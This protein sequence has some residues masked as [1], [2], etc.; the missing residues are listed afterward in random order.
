MKILA[1]DG[2]DKIAIDEL[3][4]MNIDI[5][6][7]HY[8]GEELIDKLKISDIAIIRSATKLDKEILEKVRNTK[9]KL[10]IRA[11]VGLDNI[12]V[13]YAMENGFIVKNTPNSSANSVAEF[14][15]GA[16][17]SLAR[18]IPIANFTCKN[19][20]WNK[21]QYQGMEIQGKVL[22][23]LGMG[24]IGKL[25][26]KKANALG[27]KVIFYDKFVESYENFK[28]ENFDELLKKSDFISIHTPFIRGNFISTNEFDIMKKGV[29]IINTSRGDNLDEDALIKAIEDEKVSGAFMDVFKKEPIENEKLIK[30]DKIYLSPHLGGATDEAQKNIGN[31]IID[32]VKKFV[33]K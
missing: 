10:L 27:M 12:D 31:E 8:S 33:T 13:D 3:S 2:L 22:G 24:N 11:G 6:L 21:K 1:N 19:N 14:V 15:I 20:K 32:I 18:F 23:I 5:D 4:K 7:N 9:L 26:A 17:I 16:I 29:Y 25:L 28:F 30:N